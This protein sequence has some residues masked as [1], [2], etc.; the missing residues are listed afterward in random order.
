MCTRAVS[1]RG[2]I[3]HK[4]NLYHAKQEIH[5][6]LNI[7]MSH[8]CDQIDDEIKWALVRHSMMMT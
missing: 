8:T 6:L 3:G 5:V 7:L 4:T 2:P 1:N